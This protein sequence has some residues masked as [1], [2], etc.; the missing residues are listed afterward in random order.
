MKVLQ[1]DA[2]MLAQVM[3]LRKLGIPAMAISSLT[4]KEDVTAAYREIE[5]GTGTRLVYGEGPG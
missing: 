5:T 3:G 2:C 1:L 4:P